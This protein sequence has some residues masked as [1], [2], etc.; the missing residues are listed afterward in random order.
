MSVEATISSLATRQHG[1]VTRGQLLAAN[2]SKDVVDRRLRTGWLRP[3][4]RG[5]FSVGPLVE[6]R[7]REMAA[8]LACGPK[9]VVSHLSA[10]VLWRLLSDG[11]RPEVVEV[12]VPDRHRRRPGVRT[13]HPHRAGGRHHPPTP[14]DVRFRIR[15]FTWSA[16]VSC[17]DREGSRGPS[18]GTTPPSGLRSF[19]YAAPPPSVQEPRPQLD[20]RVPRPCHAPD[21]GARR[22]RRLLPRP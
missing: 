9:A 21:R 8:V 18:G 3:L 22:F 2:V 13:P 12:I 15:R 1:V 7:A 6:T 14:P 19:R 17:A 20:P 4:H 5:V 11:Y 16:Q 10:A